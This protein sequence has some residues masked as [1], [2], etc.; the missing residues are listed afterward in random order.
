MTTYPGLFR[1]AA[2][3]AAILLAFGAERSGAGAQAGAGGRA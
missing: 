2:L 3:A 1:V